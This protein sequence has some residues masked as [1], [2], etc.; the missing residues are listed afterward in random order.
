MC[1]PLFVH[2]GTQA[3]AMCTPVTQIC[4][5]HML[6]K[7]KPP[8]C[9]PDP[10]MFMCTCQDTEPGGVTT[11][12][13]VAQNVCHGDSTSG[14]AGQKG[15]G[16][17]SALSQLGQLLGQLMKGGG[18]GGGD[19]PPPTTPTTPLTGCQGTPFQTSDV[20]QLSNP[21]AQY[22]PPTTNPVNFTTP[23]ST[24][25]DALT[26]A[27][28]GCTSGTP[29]NCP[30][31]AVDCG[32]GYESTAQ[33]GVDANN[34]PL[35]NQCVLPGGAT[36]TGTQNN[37]GVSSILCSASAR[38]IGLCGG[39]NL[40]GLGTSSALQSGMTGNIFLQG[41]GVTVTANSVNAGNNSTVA[42]FYGSNTIGG[43]QPQGL[44][45]SL[46]QNRPWNGGL[47]GGLI[48]ASFFDGLCTWQ[49]YQVGTS[50]P[51][52]A[53]V[54]DVQQTA[55]APVAKQP[56]ATTTATTTAAVPAKV[57]I[58]AVP[59]SVSLNTRTSIFWN[60]TGVTSCTETSP[61]GSFN[62][63]SVSGGAA[64]VPLESATTFTISCLDTAG[65]PVTGFVTVNLSI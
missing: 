20:S 13:C 62:Q 44:A 60:A 25:C 16:L 42:G 21:C 52:T 4:G 28:G 41:N 1:L 3:D 32:P 26:Q 43:Q 33:I 29:V 2:A 10:N 65:N 19:S 56:S 14:G 58:W 11:G 35:P 39:P 61:D 18:S 22:V 40:S 36:S 34:C 31:V 51:Q 37:N 27:L 12:H 46:C 5:C 57:Q 30:P 8:S 48:P 55:P 64:T 59:P 9:Q 47:F 50:T 45:A 49:G 24:T 54:V 15:G 63:S 23:T 38:L 7:G 17:D 53:P 6:L